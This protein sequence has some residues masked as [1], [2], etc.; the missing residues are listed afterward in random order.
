M[1]AALS[2]GSRRQ[3]V[4]CRKRLLVS[5]RSCDD[6]RRGMCRVR[7]LWYPEGVSSDVA[8]KLRLSAFAAAAGIYVFL[9][10]G[11]S[12]R[13]CRLRAITL[14]AQFVID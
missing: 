3:P 14:P 13:Y 9:A 12:D 7:A 2:Q 8:S 10:S 4:V 6:S 5:N 11:L 1:L